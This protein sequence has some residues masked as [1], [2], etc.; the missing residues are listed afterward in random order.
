MYTGG[1]FGGICGTGTPY[2]L[3]CPECR[4]RHMAKADEIRTLAAME[5]T[6]L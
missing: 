1:W 4:D 3:L 2:Y 6:N 5:G